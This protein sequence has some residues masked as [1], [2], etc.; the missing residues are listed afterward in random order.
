MGTIHPADW[1]AAYLL[2]C[3]SH[4]FPGGFLGGKLSVELIG[5]PSAFPSSQVWVDVKKIP[6]GDQTVAAA[7]A[8]AGGS[9]ET[10][11]LGHMRG[12]EAAV[13]LRL[14][15]D[16]QRTPPILLLR[17]V[18]GLQLVE[19]DLKKLG[20]RD[21]VLDVLRGFQL[22]NVPVFVNNCLVH[23]AAG[24]RPVVLMHRLA[25]PAE[26]LEMQAGGRRCVTCF[27][28]AEQIGAE[29]ED[30]YAPFAVKDSV[31]FA[32]HDLQHMEK[33]TEPSYYCEQVGFLRQ[34]LPVHAWLR[35]GGSRMS[36]RILRQDVAHVISDM[37]TCCF[38]LLEFLLARWSCASKRTVLP[39]LEGDAVA[40]DEVL[41]SEL[42]LILDMLTGDR[43]EGREQGRPPPQPPSK[44]CEV[45]PV[46]ALFHQLGCEQLAREVGEEDGGAQM[47]SRWP[48]IL[49][50]KELCTYAEP[51]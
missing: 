6:D 32:I 23:W 41:S 50:Q 15:T 38:H 42:T 34:M 3:L 5:D 35:G 1:V 48:M 20:D 43:L 44:P 36:D 16:P 4:I 13:E 33:L 45:A 37:N 49:S 27:C 51:Q 8:E 2:L 29:W 21:T 25:T 24:M 14:D 22:K 26:V 30:G 40:T 39:E 9:A 17:E 46:R 7:A 18:E 12:E 11:D 47:R 31:H 28:E 19:R 10:H